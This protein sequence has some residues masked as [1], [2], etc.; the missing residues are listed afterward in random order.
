MI[1]QF[2][3]TLLSVSAVCRLIPTQLKHRRSRIVIKISFMKLFQNLAQIILELLMGNMRRKKLSHI[4]NQRFCLLGIWVRL[5]KLSNYIQ[6]VYLLFIQTKL[7]SHL[8]FIW[9]YVIAYFDLNR[10]ATKM[11]KYPDIVTILCSFV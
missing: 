9:T 8:F 2:A 5:T 4:H 1:S 10:K 6:L 3:C 7:S 11:F